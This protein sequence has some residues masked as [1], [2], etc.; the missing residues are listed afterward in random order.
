VSSNDKT[1]MLKSVK[2]GVLGHKMEKLANNGLHSSR[3]VIP[4]TQLRLIPG[5]L[6]IIWRRVLKTAISAYTLN[7]FNLKSVR[8]DSSVGVATDY[9]LDDRMIGVRVPAGCG[10]FSLRHRVQTGSGSRPASYP[11]DTGGS[12]PGSKATGAWS[13]PHTSI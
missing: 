1:F 4:H 11:M 7:L 13:W 6:R 3:E 9:G 10:N 12:F 5:S 8:W 2:I